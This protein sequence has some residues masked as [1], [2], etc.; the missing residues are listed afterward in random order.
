MIVRRIKS[1]GAGS[2]INNYHH[3][4]SN[5][6]EPKLV[7]NQS[8]YYGQNEQVAHAGTSKSTTTSTKVDKN[9]RNIVNHDQKLENYPSTILDM[10]KDS[11]LNEDQI[12]Q[13]RQTDSPRGI[14]DAEGLNRL[15]TVG[16]AV[17][18]DFYDFIQN[19]DQEKLTGHE[20]I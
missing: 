3:S 17:T 12:Q 16:A 19:G 4:T 9:S 20:I 7:H 18:D 15:K 1:G 5:N 2:Q 8:G 10:N 13:Y 14:E 6:N 11:V